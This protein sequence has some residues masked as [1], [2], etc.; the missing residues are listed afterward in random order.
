MFRFGTHDQGNLSVQSVL[1]Q[2]STY[3]VKTGVLVYSSENNYMRNYEF[4]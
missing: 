1:Q 4:K 3:I 2:S